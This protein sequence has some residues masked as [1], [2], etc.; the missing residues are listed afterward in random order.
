MWCEE[1]MIYERTNVFLAQ[2]FEIAQTLDTRKYR[3]FN[4]YPE[5]L[6]HIEIEWRL[7]A[8]SLVPVGDGEYYESP[9][10]AP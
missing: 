2:I 10:V 6:Y 4:Y 9:Y 5:L 1:I 8:N 7:I 3:F